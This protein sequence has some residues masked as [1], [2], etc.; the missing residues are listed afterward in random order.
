LTW[1]GAGTHH[2][3]GVSTRQE[4]EGAQVIGVRS[5][6]ATGLLVALSSGCLDERID[7]GDV[8]WSTACNCQVSL[9]DNPVLREDVL[10]T[11]T[12]FPEEAERVEGEKWAYQRFDLQMD[13][14]APGSDFSEDDASDGASWL[15]WPSA[16][17]KYS[18]PN[19]P[20]G[21]VQM[22]WEMHGA[23]LS[24]NRGQVVQGAV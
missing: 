15:P 14:D 17:G 22:P 10:L 2:R 4:W 12:P 13:L 20:G 7:D 3:R 19:S 18:A 21:L 1:T 5:T 11:D 23:R 6:L 9:R 24:G 8:R 16:P